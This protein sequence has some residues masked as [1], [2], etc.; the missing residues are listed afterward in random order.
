[1]EGLVMYDIGRPTPHDYT[2]FFL[3]MTY[4][5]LPVSKYVCYRYGAG[6]R[7]LNTVTNS[8]HSAER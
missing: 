6:L 2:M 8:H 5:D 4:T 3:S 1:M 7:H